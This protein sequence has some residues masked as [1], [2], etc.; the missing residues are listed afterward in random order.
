VIGELISLY[1]RLLGA[2]LQSQLQYRASLVL[3]IVGDALITLLDFVVTALLFYR[4][5]NLAGWSLG[6]VAFLFGIGGMA[7]GISDMVCSGIDRLSI[8]IQTGTFDRVLTRPLPAFVQ[9][10]AGD[11]QLRRLGR[12]AQAGFVL[13]LAINFVEVS[14]TPLKVVVLLSAVLSGVI[15][16]CSIWTIGG[17]VTFWTVQTSEVTNVF[18]YGGSYVTQYPMS[19]Y[20]DWLRH[21]F[22]FVVPVGFIS[23]LPSLFVLERFDPLGLPAALQFCSPLAALTFA[24]PALCAWLLGVRHY[25]STGS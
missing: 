17:A 21:F 16:Y 13:F 1:V 15:I 24:V 7:F 2:Q 10:L 8:A 12:I 25:Q 11:F 6:E 5:P 19:I 18:T 20:A 22:I 23:Y 4:F 9:V 14:W 3:Q